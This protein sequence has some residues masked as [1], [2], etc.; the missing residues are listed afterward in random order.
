MPDHDDDAARLAVAIGRINRRIRPS[1]D[2]LTLGQ[3]SILSTI[4]RRGPLRLGDLAR[5]EAVAAPTVTRVVADLER[6]GM[7]GRET[8]VADRRSF[9]V[10]DTPAGEEAVLRARAERAE[11]V[12]ALLDQLDD[13][14][15]A[16]I[17]A[18]LDALE[19][20]A[21]PG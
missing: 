20:I 6:R 16:A 18:A 1:G 2:G 3:L 14:Q 21:E 5:I 10:S 12:S 15:R 8:D 17:A 19:V 11:R 13:A 9:L 7:V 4:S